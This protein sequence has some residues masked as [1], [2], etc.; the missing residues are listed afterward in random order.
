[1]SIS[2]AEAKR[3]LVDRIAAEAERG[4]APL[5]EAETELLGFGEGEAGMTT[6]ER[7]RTSEREDE[8]YENRI[9][10]LAKAVYDRDVEAG[11]KA[12]WDEALDELAAEDLYLFVMLE[13]AG[14]VKTTSHLVMPD[15]RMMVGVVPPLICVALAIVAVTPVGGRLIPSLAVRLGIAVALLLAP[16]AL[17]RLRGRRES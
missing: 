2:V 16:F 12:E 11:R 17:G 15:W 13:R 3:F 14:L 4:G 5:D 1:M 6:L 7:A 10:R 8:E 9:A